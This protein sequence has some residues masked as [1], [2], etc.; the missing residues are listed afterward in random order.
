MISELGSDGWIRVRWDTGLIN[1]YRM[2][3]KCD[4]TLAPSEVHPKPKEGD[5]P[6]APTDVDLKVGMARGME[7]AD[8]PT[9][10]I[11]Q[12]GVCL[13]QSLVVGVGLHAGQ[14][15]P[16]T[17]TSVATL[18]HHIVQCGKKKGTLLPYT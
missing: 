3:D 6:D 8:A 4:L 13:L 5:A 15:H 14:L 16:R 18:M 7:G 12:S 17:T 10:L 11:L 2:E 1:S 9:S